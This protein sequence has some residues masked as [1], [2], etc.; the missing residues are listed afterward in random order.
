MIYLI[1]LGFDEKT[2]AFFSKEKKK[3][4][5]SQTERKSPKSRR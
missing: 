4:H 1:R 3:Y 5:T 2:I